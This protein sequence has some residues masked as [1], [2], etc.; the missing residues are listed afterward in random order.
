MLRDYI[1]WKQQVVNTDFWTWLIYPPCGFVTMS[2]W[3]IPHRIYFFSLK[4][5][6]Q[7]GFFDLVKNSHWAF[8]GPAKVSRPLVIP[9][10]GARSEITKKIDLEALAG[11]QCAKWTFGR[12]YAAISDFFW[13]YWP[14]HIIQIFVVQP[15]HNS[16][17]TI[18]CHVLAKMKKIWICL[19]SIKL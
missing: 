15:K 14:N 18:S 5:G 16:K 17:Q 4:Q 19:I 10:E 8:F 6:F 13:F 12:F 11:P 2:T 7:I 3:K 9:K 1:W